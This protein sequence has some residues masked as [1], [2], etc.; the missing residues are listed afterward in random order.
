MSDF[1]R[2]QLGVVSRSEG[3]SAA[4]RSAYQSCGRIVD[5][6]GKVFDF[7]RKASEHV[8]TI[9][10][11]PRDAPDWMQQPESLWQRAAAAEKRVD[12]QEAR[13]LD[14][15]MP[16]AVPTELWEACVRHI[17]DP[18]IDMGMA[19]QI[20]IHNTPASDGGRNI[21]VHGLATLRPIDGGR[22]ATRKNRDWNNH[23]RERNGRAVRELFAERLTSFCGEHNID[24]RGDARSNSERD[25]PHPEPELPRW[26]FEYAQRT[27]ELPEALAAL[28]DHRKRRREW[29]AS[30]AEEIEA[31]LDLRQL[32]IQSR[33]Q[34]Q[35]RLIPVDASKGPSSK[36]DR[37]A[38]ILRAWYRGEWINADSIPSI[39]SVRFDETRGLLWIDLTDGTTLIDRGDAITMRG[40][41][42][43]SGALET[44]AAAQRH[45][46]RSVNVW[47]DQT[48][49]DAVAVACMLRGIEVENHVL[50]SKAQVLF[51]RLKAE[52]T[53]RSIESNETADPPIE[54]RKQ[55]PDLVTSRFSEAHS[56]Q[57]IYQQIA[58]RRLVSMPRIKYLRE[59]DDSAPIYTPRFKMPC[60]SHTKHD[61]KRD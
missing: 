28:H 29:E 49:K 20:D 40:A 24:Y 52:Q 5:H 9:V 14:F 59:A 2:V 25:L 58:K 47:G 4:K 51:A 19:M 42:T 36:R 34:H 31:E 6:E 57:T 26:N 18:Y 37:R 22:F 48:Y 17:Y 1:F 23:F 44:A 13:I 27:G 33:M 45:G 60:E 43:W 12:A 21:N 15:S 38:A 16:R 35:R 61:L 8:R 50:S 3:H 53:D 39:A 55:S 41:V 56:S 30:Q 54:A 7:S 32:E 11:T 46:W 10:L